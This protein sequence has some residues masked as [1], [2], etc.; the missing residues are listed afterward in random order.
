MRDILNYI[1]YPSGQSFTTDL[2]D[3]IS[4][5]F[6]SG[7]TNISVSIELEFDTFYNLHRDSLPHHPFPVDRSFFFRYPN[8]EGGYQ[9]SKSPVYC[10]PYSDLSSNSSASLLNMLLQIVKAFFLLSANSI[11]TSYLI[12]ISKSAFSKYLPVILVPFTT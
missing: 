4:L 8:C 12:P 10:C 9:K 7:T 5:T 2:R 1:A 11:C 6:P 3:N